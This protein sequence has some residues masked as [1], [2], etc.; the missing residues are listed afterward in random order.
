MEGGTEEAY[1]YRRLSWLPA[2]EYRSVRLAPD[3]FP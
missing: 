3:S 1:V 2:D